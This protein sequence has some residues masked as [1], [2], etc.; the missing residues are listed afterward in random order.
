[1]WR[2]ADVVCHEVAHQWFGNLIT[3]ADWPDLTVNEGLASF[4]EYKCLQGVLPDLPG[5]ALRQIATSPLGV[6]CCF[7]YPAL[8]SMGLASCMKHKCLQ[9]VL[10]V[11]FFP[12]GHSS[13]CLHH[14]DGLCQ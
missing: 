3:A 5:Q 12:L 9:G 10:L 1:M 11:L 7:L 6:C 8:C 14:S 2:A 4:M 13:H